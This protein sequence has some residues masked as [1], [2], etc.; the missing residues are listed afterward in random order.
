MQHSQTWLT[1]GTGSGERPT[2]T[3]PERAHAFHR[4][5]KSRPVN[6]SVALPRDFPPLPQAAR[7]ELAR[8]W[9]AMSG[10]LGFAPSVPYLDAY[11]AMYSSSV[12][13]PS[14][15]RPRKD[16]DRFV[17]EIH[18]LTTIR[19]ARTL[20]LDIRTRGVPG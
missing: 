12:I 20:H 18:L 10:H 4:P 2:P 5:G 15:S 9:H 14:Q 1:S 8:I 19:E 17:A 3:L 16:L 6:D 11:Q 13:A 7:P